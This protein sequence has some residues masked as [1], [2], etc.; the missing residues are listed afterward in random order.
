MYLQTV[1]NIINNPFVYQIT[2][3][4]HNVQ[5]LMEIR[6]YFISLYSYFTYLYYIYIIYA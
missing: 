3:S 6:T 5:I 2:N 1:T 4:E